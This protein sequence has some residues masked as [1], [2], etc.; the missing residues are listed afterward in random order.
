MKTGTTNKPYLPIIFYN[1]FFFEIFT[2]EKI[3][4]FALRIENLRICLV[5]F[6]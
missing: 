6:D 4:T 1:F 2:F 3:L 5:L